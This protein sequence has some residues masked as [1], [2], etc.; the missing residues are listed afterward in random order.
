MPRFRAA[1][2]RT[3]RPGWPTVPLALLVI[4]RTSRPSTRIRSNRRARS[5]LTFSVQSRRRALSLPLRRAAASRVLARRL[6]P[7]RWRA[8]R[9]SNRL[10]RCRSDWRRPGTDSNSPVESAAET[11]TPRS[12][13]TIS[14]VPGPGMTGG[15]ARERK[16]PPAGAIPRYPVGLGVGNRARPAEPYPTELGDQ[17]FPPAAIE[18]ACILWSR[19]GDTEALVHIALAPRRRGGR[20]GAL[21][22]GELGGSAAP[23]GQLGL[24]EWKSR[25]ACCWTITLPCASH[26]N[27]ARASVSCRHCSANPGAGRPGCHHDRCSTARFHT[28]RAWAQCSRSAVSCGGVGYRR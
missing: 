13:P 4:A 10:R 3:L 12:T 1:F 9:R 6:E 21:L 2:R 7:F 19:G 24:A 23:M 8:L 22:R 20:R 17:H 27:A 28:N 16:M 14:S 15:I 26:G 11:A 5:V 25:R 18:A